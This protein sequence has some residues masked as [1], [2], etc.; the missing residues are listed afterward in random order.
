MAVNA[1]LT[2]SAPVSDSNWLTTQK[3][4]IDSINQLQKEIN[5]LSTSFTTHVD[6]SQSDEFKKQSDFAHDIAILRADHT[7]LSSQQQIIINLIK[8]RQNGGQD[9]GQE[10]KPAESHSQENGHKKGKRKHRHRRRHGNQLVVKDADGQG[11]SDQFQLKATKT[12]TDLSE[13][14]NALHDI[15][16]SLFRDLQDLE[17]KVSDNDDK[18][19]KVE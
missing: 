15:T 14:V 4:L 3:W 2:L 16:I 13:E 10:T 11:A 18:V 17:K 5:E 19:D 1:M 8:Q 7:V 12:I 9:D 6:S